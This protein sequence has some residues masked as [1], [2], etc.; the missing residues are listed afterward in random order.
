MNLII[1]V[2]DKYQFIVICMLMYTRK[3]TQPHTARRQWLLG[4]ALSIERNG[5]G[6]AFLNVDTNRL[7]NSKSRYDDKL[8]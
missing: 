8:G 6:L 2:L 5:A 1:D 3:N 4:Q 7:T